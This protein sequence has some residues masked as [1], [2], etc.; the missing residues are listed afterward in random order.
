MNCQNMDLI[1]SL[2]RSFFKVQK[3]REKKVKIRYFA[4]FWKRRPDNVSLFLVYSFLGMI[5]I[6]CQEMDLIDFFE[7]SFSRLKRSALAYSVV[8]KWCSNLLHHVYALVCETNPVLKYE[9]CRITLKVIFKVR[10]VQFEP[11]WSIRAN[12]LETVHVMTNVSMK[13]IYIKSYIIFLLKLRP[14]T[15]DDR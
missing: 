8:M 14:L 15:L 13:H 12:I 4:T 9:R 6:N 5:L 1:E 11:L 7:R 2:Y 3:V 10:N